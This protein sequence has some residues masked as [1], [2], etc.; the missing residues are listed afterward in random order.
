[1]NKRQINML[2]M[3]IALLKYIAS[4]VTITEKLPLFKENVKLVSNEVDAI[5]A[6]SELQNITYKGIIKKKNEVRLKMVNMAIDNAMK[7]EA[8]AKHNKNTKLLTEVSTA[9]MGVSKARESKKI[10]LAKIILD[11]ATP[12]I[13]QL[14]TYGI[15]LKT[16]DDFKLSIDEFNKSIGETKLHRTKEKQV[17]AGISKHFD[18]AYE[19]LLIMDSAVDVVRLD[20]KE[21]YA[22]YKDIRKVD[23]NNTT[24]R[25]IMINVVEDG[26]DKPIYNAEIILTLISSKD[27]VLTEELPIKKKTGKK[28]N[29]YSENNTQGTYAYN[30]YKEGYIVEAG[31]T[32]INDKETT[33]LTI[34]LKKKKN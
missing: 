26:T 32:V 5:Q 21:F 18:T 4:Y 30:I 24:T 34:R 10:D 6:A 25:S 17:T 15:T 28:G 8:Y 33:K 12:I 27:K 19:S 22:G 1:M 23:T 11:E 2:S 3:L 14:S 29:I 16:Q 7:I 9:R 20:E 31:T 13:D